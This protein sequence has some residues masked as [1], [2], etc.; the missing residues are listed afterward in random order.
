[1]RPD[2]FFAEDRYDGG[3]RFIDRERLRSV[4]SG[5]LAS[6]DDI[7]VAAPLARLVH[8][9]LEAFGTGGGE[10]MTNDDMREAILALR[11]LVDRLGL[12]GFEPPFRDFNSFRTYWIREGAA[13]SGGYQARRNLL[14]QQ[15]DSLH[16][17][18][19]D[20]ETR[21]LSAT[22]V[23]PVSAH[24]RTGWSAVDIEISELRRHF[25]SARTPQDYRAVGNDCVAV[26]E[27]LSRQ[28]FDSKVH[29]RPGETEPPVANTKQRLDRFIEEALPGAEN[30]A[31]RKLA[32]AVIEL[33][34]SVKH[35]S[36]PARREA[37]I[38]AD[39]V[40]QLANMLRRLS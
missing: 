27:A 1:M 5:R 18:L 22:L 7:E 19:A 30:A 17:T 9:E 13:G 24:P 11:A 4:R 2:D 14:S 15:F 37:G 25:R 8:D 26:T 34:Q 35:S 32:R 29:L 31:L 36:A 23:E 16:D 28:V 21:A 20:L 39:A 10:E 12:A 38:C 3:R 6:H 40:I 33:S